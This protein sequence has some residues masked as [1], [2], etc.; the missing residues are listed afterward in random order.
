[1]DDSSLDKWPNALRWILAWPIALL[2]SLIIAWLIRLFQ[3][4]LDEHMASWLL[5]FIQ[6]GMIGYLFVYISAWFAPNYK[7]VVSII[8]LCIIVALIFLLIG[9]V[10]LG[11]R[12]G[13]T[14]DSPWLFFITAA[15]YIFGSVIASAQ[16]HSE[17]KTE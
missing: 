8:S 6:A 15:I 2:G 5:D 13:A 12:Y 7:K 3:S 17:A 9:F 4:G 14:I 1:M 16:I 11:S 10:I